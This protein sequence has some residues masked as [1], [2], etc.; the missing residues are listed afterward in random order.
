MPAVA[1]RTHARYDEY[2][3]FER[4]AANK[5]EYYDG[6]IYA[7]AGGTPEHSLLAAN[8]IYELRRALGERTCSVYT[9]DLRI[10]VLATGL[11]TYP[12]VA[13]VCGPSERA[14]DD[15]DAVT[16]PI[17]LAEVLSDST[18]AYDR[19]EKFAHYRRVPSL[20]E[21]VLVSQ[22]ERRVEVYQ[23]A[24]RRR[25]MLTDW[26]PGERAALSSLELELSVDEVYRGLG[27]GVPAGG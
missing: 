7:M 19:G 2:L 9:S 4:E 17:V 23:R 16:N 15:P 12:D 18:E 6:S 13:V 11:S 20:R 8:V 14:T 3:A 10:R 27:L 1:V 25:W 5:H 26:G 21:Y 24:E 22:R